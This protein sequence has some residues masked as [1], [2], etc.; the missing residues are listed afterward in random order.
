MLRILQ[1][2]ARF[3]LK[4]DDLVTMDHVPNLNRPT[5]DFAV[6]D[7]GLASHGGIQH[8]RNFF[9]AIGTREK[10]FHN[11]YFVLTYQSGSCKQIPQREELT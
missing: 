7:V 4:F 5:A 9:T 8:Y 11:L 3:C 6:F 1:L 2:P 10:V